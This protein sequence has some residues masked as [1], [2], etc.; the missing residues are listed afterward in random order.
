MILPFKAKPT[1]PENKL[2]GNMAEC[3]VE[4]MFSRAGYYV[5]RFGYESSIQYLK[6]LENLKE[7]ET[8]KMIKSMPDFVAVD[9]KGRVFF[10]EVK[11]RTDWAKW[12]EDDHKL[13]ELYDHW[14]N[15]ILVMV[16]NKEPYFKIAVMKDFMLKRKLHQ[17]G[18]FKTI[19]INK[20]ILKEYKALIQKYFWGHGKD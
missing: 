4:Q 16:S 13:E 15:V 7:N 14:K 5:F 2:K 17:F 8:L 20:K 18:N 6:N 3:L 12:K 19:S 11:Y 9:K 10:V 1:W